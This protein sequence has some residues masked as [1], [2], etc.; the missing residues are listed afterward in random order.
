MANHPTRHF[1]IIGDAEV[2]RTILTDPSTTKPDLYKLIRNITGGP[3]MLTMSV[4]HAWKKKR[5]STSSAFSSN[6]V[7]R[8][9]Q[10]SILLEIRG[11]TGLDCC[12]TI[13]LCSIIICIILS[14]IFV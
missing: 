2:A 10:V 7:K 12:L 1:F 11:R 4:G 6:H 8:I 3:A 5:K 13:L 9:T 14:Q